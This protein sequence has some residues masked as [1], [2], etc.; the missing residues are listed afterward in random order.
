MKELAK[1]G[2]VPDD[3]LIDYVITGIKDHEKY[4][5]I[6]YGATDLQDFKRKLEL[7]SKISQRMIDFSSH[8]NYR[9]TPL[10]GQSML[11][12]YN[13]G[14]RG[15]HAMNCPDAASVLRLSVIRAQG[16]R[17]FKY[18]IQN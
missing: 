16:G 6:L 17:L 4:K 8:N 13:C 2:C 14:A 7:Y 1:H 10:I 12:C 11:R 5:M 9:T 3:S 18:S 15:H